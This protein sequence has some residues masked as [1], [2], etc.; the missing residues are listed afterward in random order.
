MCV[1][2]LS[3]RVEAILLKLLT[4]S[5]PVQFVT[6]PIFRPIR[7]WFKSRIYMTYSFFITRLRVSGAAIINVSMAP[8]IAAE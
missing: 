5:L 2:Q 4:E 6:Q 7:V 8:H 3:D 1:V